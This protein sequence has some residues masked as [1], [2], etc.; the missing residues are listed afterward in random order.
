MALN[1]DFKEENGMEYEI[2][3]ARPVTEREKLYGYGTKYTHYFR[4][5]V[6]Y[7][8]VKK[9]YEELK[10]KFPDCKLEVT[11]WQRVGNIVDMDKCDF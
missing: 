4:V 7:G 5:T 1:D 8:S 10:E 11:A 3:V 9:V 2:N 6:P